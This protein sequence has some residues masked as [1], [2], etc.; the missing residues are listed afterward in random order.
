MIQA[1]VSSTETKRLASHPN[2]VLGI[3]FSGAL[4]A[5]NRIWIAIGCVV[6]NTLRLEDCY[7]AKDLPGSSVSRDICLAALRR[8]VGTQRGCVCG[9]DFPFGLPRSLVKETSWKESILHFGDRYQSP[10]EFREVC[11]AASPGNELKRLT[12]RESE[13]PFSPYNLRIFRQTYF[14]IRDVLAPLVKDKLA[15]VLP[16]QKPSPDKSWIVE[17]CPASTLKRKLHPYPS[18]KGSNKGENEA[19]AHILSR[20]GERGYVLVPTVLQSRVVDDQGGD[21]LDSI[22]AAEVAFRSAHDPIGFRIFRSQA[23]ALEG[24]VYV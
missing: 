3:D 21:A 19:R 23:Y 22:I 10:E 2:R 15:C 1:E 20:I 16:M 6:G 11:R 9:M 18:Y 14:G 8:F 17:V 4:N 13:T 12:D 24:Y 7:P 5:G